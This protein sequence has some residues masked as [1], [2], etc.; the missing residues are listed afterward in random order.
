M[1]EH[2]Q[3]FTAGLDLRRFVIQRIERSSAHRAL[4]VPPSMPNR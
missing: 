2:Q 4:S 3:A 1:V